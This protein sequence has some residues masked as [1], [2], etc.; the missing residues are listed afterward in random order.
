MY[1]SHK[2]RKHLKLHKTYSGS[3][4]QALITHHAEKIKGWVL[5]LTPGERAR[6]PTG[7][8]VLHFTEKRYK[9]N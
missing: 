1:M 9:K 2:I 7:W 5:G 6:I 3:G 4:A 8:G